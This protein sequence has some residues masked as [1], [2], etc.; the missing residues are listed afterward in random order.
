MPAG[1]GRA[2]SFH[3]DTIWAR[4]ASASTGTWRSGVAGASSSAAA[5]FARQVHTSAHTAAGSASPTAL[6]VTANPVPASS[7]ATVSG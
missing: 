2:V 3:P 1:T 5:R 6:T 7:T 4:S